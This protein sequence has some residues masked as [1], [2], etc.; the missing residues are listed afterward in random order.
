MGCNT[1]RAELVVCSLRPIFRMENIFHDELFS[2]TSISYLRP[3][4]PI[5]D[6]RKQLL[7]TS[8]KTHALFMYKDRGVIIFRATLYEV[9][10]YVAA[11]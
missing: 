4:N 7:L 9:I 10:V 6:T 3:L 11:S 5:T 1:S 8:S 2:D